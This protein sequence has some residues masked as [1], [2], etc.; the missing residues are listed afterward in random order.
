MHSALEQ[1]SSFA[2][3]GRSRSPHA[4]PTAMSTS[5]QSHR[6]WRVGSSM[7]CIYSSDTAARAGTT[8]C[9]KDFSAMDPNS[10]HRLVPKMAN[11]REV[12]G[13]TRG[14]SC[15][16]HGSR[17]AANPEGLVWSNV[18]NLEGSHSCDGRWACS[19][20]HRHATYLHEQNE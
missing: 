17:A 12:V 10:A 4:H 1:P 19:Y 2:V 13:S 8:H 9:T 20:A 3:L 15:V 18:G 16:S 6:T 14:S 11:T 5:P 7:E